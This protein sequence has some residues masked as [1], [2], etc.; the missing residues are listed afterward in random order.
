MDWNIKSC[1]RTVCVNVCCTES[2]RG[3]DFELSDE[4]VGS[5]DIQRGDSKHSVRVEDTVLLQHLSGD[6]DSGI[7]LKDTPRFN[8]S[9]ATG[10]TQVQTH[11][12]IHR[13]QPA[14]FL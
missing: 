3:T 5:D 2:V 9:P 1:L 10:S 12:P 14:L 4:G 8:T 7:Y 11:T 13:L 6:G